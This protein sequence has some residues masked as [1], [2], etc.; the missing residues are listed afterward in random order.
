MKCEFQKDSEE[1]G[2]QQP[3]REKMII[4][5]DGDGEWGSKDISEAEKFT[6]CGRKRG[7][8]DRPGVLGVVVMLLTSIGNT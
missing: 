1:T 5:A 8:C 3:V 2:Q 7:L 4:Q 6:E